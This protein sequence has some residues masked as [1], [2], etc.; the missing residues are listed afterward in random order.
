MILTKWIRLQHH[1]DGVR[2]GFRR[3][4]E[5]SAHWPSPSPREMTLRK[6]TA[7]KA[8]RA[9]GEGSPWISKTSDRQSS[10]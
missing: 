7:A 10:T 4:N 9:G 2:S 3:R 8:G 6:R 1:F 5:N